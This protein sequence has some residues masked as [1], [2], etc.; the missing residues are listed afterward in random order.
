MHCE[1]KPFKYSPFGK[2][3]K[4]R[5]PWNDNSFNFGREKKRR[6]LKTFLWLSLSRDVPFYWKRFVRNIALLFGLLPC[7]TPMESALPRSAQICQDVWERPSSKNFQNPN[8][9]HD[10]RDDHAGPRWKVSY[11]PCPAVFLQNFSLLICYKWAKQVSWDG[12][13]TSG[14][15]FHSMAYICQDVWEG[16]RSIRND[17]NQGS[18]NCA[19]LPFRMGQNGK[20]GKHQSDDLKHFIYVSKSKHSFCDSKRPICQPNDSKHS[21]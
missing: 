11:W 17:C 4:N 7:W 14:K 10:N 1:S 15:W 2:S 5:I 13:L 16:P 8:N 21:I 18:T 20:D 6:Q 9:I 19:I 3:H 12:N